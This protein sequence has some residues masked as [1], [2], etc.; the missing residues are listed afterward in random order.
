M[1][2]PLFSSYLELCHH[3]RPGDLI[4][5][6]GSDLP[7]L[8]VKLATVSRYVHVAIVLSVEAG[9]QDPVL[10][11]ESHIDLSLPSVGTGKRAL[12][13]QT[14]WLTNRLA[15]VQGPVWWTALKTPLSGQQL[16]TMQNWLLAAEQAQIP[17]DFPQAIAAGLPLLE[18]LNFKIAPDESA[19][20][21]SELATRA[22][23]IAGVLDPMLNPAEQT[24]TD[25]M[26]FSCFKPP[27]LIQ[28]NEA[29]LV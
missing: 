18:Y 1:S 17:F 15:I 13:V 6:S 3:I 24:P 14:Q 26:Q 10:I 22:L 29:K 23:Q 25:V 20:F 4:T 12:G 5:F 7:S 28:D 11:A 9:R 2:N 19:L 21:C 27:V 16:K 8:I